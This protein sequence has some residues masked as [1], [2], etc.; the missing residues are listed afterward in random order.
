MVG[1]RFLYITLTL[2]CLSLHLSAQTTADGFAQ[3]QMRQLALRQEVVEQRLSAAR[4]EYTTRPCDSLGRV[5]HE[6]EKQTVAIDEAIE[7]VRQQEAERLEAAEAATEQTEEPSEGAT[8]P[9]EEKKD[10]AASEPEP[11]P[12]DESEIKIEEQPQPTQQELVISD[13]LKSLFNTSRRRYALTQREIKALIEEYAVAY[14]KI[15]SALEGYEEATS[16]QTLEGCYADYLAAAEEAGRIAD[17]VAD[18][19]DKL[20]ASKVMSY[21]GFADSLGLDT[22][23]TRHTAL[24]DEI[25]RSMN[26]KLAGR[27]SDIDLAMYPH[28]LRNTLLFE[29]EL[30][31]YIEPEIADS[32]MVVAQNY[33]CT[34]TL[35]APIGI[36][37]RADVKFAPIKIKK[38]GKEKSVASLPTLKVPS[39]G[40]LYSITVANYASLPPSTKVFRGATPL[41][42]ERREDGRTYIYLGLYPT[43]RSAQDDIALLRKAGFKQPTLV[44]WRDGIRRDDFVDRHNATTKP[45]AAMFRVEITGA[46]GALPQDVVSLIRE[47]APRK[48]ISKYSAA[49]GSTVFT[50]GIFTKESEAKALATAIS[51]SSPNL[52]ATLAQVGKK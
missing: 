21:S 12:V 51:K 47:K 35:F 11:T 19:S 17:Q 44:M 4:E 10:E 49:D 38:G 43:A 20:F 25:E 16:L 30:A 26:E 52:T 27:C 13:N 2:C 18:R 37:K 22:L 41:Y 46:E 7:R 8:S 45:K 39:K 14:G 3:R 5:I 24:N 34:Y 32:L 48:E 36:P 40:E 50:I 29:A 15:A 23:R 31:Q 6:L 9:V 33:D 28:R 42:R 1:I